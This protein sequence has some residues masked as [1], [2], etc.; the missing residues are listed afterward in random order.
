M[1]QARA[2]RTRA[3]VVVSG[4]VQGV[5]FRYSLRDLAE[6]EGVQGWV[7]NLPDGRVEAVLEGDEEAVRRLVGWCYSGPPGARVWNVEVHWSEPQG[8]LRGFG[9]ERTPRRY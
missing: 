4:L 6:R 7:R 8:G 3:Q 2:R 5:G 1:S 9:I